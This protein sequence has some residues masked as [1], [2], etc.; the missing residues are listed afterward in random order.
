[1][2]NTIELLRTE[3]EELK[4]IIAGL[5]A[6]VADLEDHNRYSAV[7]G[8]EDVIGQAADDGYK[9][10]DEQAKEILETIIRQHDATIGINWDVISCHID[11]YVADNEV[12]T[13]DEEEEN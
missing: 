1:M 6:K 10:T 8:I 3:N 11:M 13:V 7:W 4:A 2:E 5:E 9:L 12:E